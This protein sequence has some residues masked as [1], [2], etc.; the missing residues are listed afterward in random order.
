[1]LAGDRGGKLSRIFEKK[2]YL[3]ITLY[4]DTGQ[5]PKGTSIDRIKEKHTLLRRE[6]TLGGR[7]GRGC[8]S[9]YVSA[10]ADDRIFFPRLAE[11]FS[12]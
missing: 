4:V 3:L 5:R 8:M 1:M 2:Q 7:G 6:G 12:F 11:A 9:V 10:A